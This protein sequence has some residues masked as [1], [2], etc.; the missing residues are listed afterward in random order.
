MRAGAEQMLQKQILPA[1][2]VQPYDTEYQKRRP[3]NRFIGR[4]NFYA[5]HSRSEYQNEQAIE[6]NSR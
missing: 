6:I 1:V 5:T 2:G 3:T 4:Q